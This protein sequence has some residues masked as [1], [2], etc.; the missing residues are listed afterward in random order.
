[1]TTWQ[2]MFDAGPCQTEVMSSNGTHLEYVQ[3]LAKG[4]TTPVFTA[5]N[6][7]QYQ[8][9]VD[10]NGVVSLVAT[11]GGTAADLMLRVITVYDSSNMLTR[12]TAAQGFCP[13]G[14]GSALNDSGT[15]NAPDGSNCIALTM[16]TGA[17]GATT[18]AT[19]TW[20]PHKPL[21][22]YGTVGM[23]ANP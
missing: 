9:G 10:A 17:M 16:P 11:D 2:S 21:Q 14:A 3:N 1:M 4:E 23:Y 12:V 20:P 19:V 18:P 7:F 8:F 15:P 13:K 22:G 6:G 5:T